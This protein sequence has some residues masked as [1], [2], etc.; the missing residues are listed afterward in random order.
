MGVPRANCCQQ[1]G[2]NIGYIGRFVFF[3]AF[4]KCDCIHEWTRW[5][6][7]V[8]KVLYFL[9]FEGEQSYQTREC[10]KCGKTQEED[11]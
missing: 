7:R 6:P 1:C 11:I 9:K 8:K 3:G 5:E 4:H 2:E 10:K